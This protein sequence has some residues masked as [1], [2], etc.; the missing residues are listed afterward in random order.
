[1]KDKLQIILLILIL[2]IS[3]ILI[4]VAISKNNF[5]FKIT[6]ETIFICNEQTGEVKIYSLS[7]ETLSDWRKLRSKQP[8]IYK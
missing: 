3:V 4:T 1:M 2:I 7:P 5:S 8:L 6:K